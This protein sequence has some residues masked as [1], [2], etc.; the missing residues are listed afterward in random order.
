MKEGFES[1]ARVEKK[2]K[3]ST[4]EEG[5]VMERYIDLRSRA[6]EPLMSSEERRAF[7][8]DLIDL[9]RALNEGKNLEPEVREELLRQVQVVEQDYLSIKNATEVVQ[10]LERESRGD[11]LVPHLYDKSIGLILAARDR[12]VPDRSL[13]PL[14]DIIEGYL[15]RVRALRG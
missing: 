14:R 6:Y 9:V 4:A 3:D 8:Q 12:G 1:G 10:Q 11:I 5:A 15:D 2:E 13:E 7:S